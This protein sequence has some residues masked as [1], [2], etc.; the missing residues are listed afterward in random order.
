VEGPAKSPQAR[1]LGHRVVPATG[2]HR[3]F[4]DCNETAASS[5]SIQV[6]TLSI[7]SCDQAFV[8]LNCYNK[9]E[10]LL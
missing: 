9:K 8:V 1:R 7:N 2:R 10:K 4:L 6:I 5:C 3:Q